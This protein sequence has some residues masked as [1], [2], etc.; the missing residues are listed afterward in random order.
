MT[1]KG[2][3]DK[4]TLYKTG[5]SLQVLSQFKHCD[6]MYPEIFGTSIL[7]KCL[8]APILKMHPKIFG[9]LVCT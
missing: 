1:H 8:G 6:A 4:A 7:A 9:S 3:S 2:K 5:H